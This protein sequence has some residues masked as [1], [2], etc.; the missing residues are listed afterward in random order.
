MVP[1]QQV[2]Y[3]EPSVCSTKMHQHI[4]YQSY[5]YIG[6]GEKKGEI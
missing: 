4:W 1:T 6:K 5:S 2:L 3:I